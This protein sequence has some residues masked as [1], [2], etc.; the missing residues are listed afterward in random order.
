QE[1]SSKSFQEL[2]SAYPQTTQEMIWDLTRYPDL[3]PL[4]IKEG[5]AAETEL[6]NLLGEYPEEVRSRALRAQAD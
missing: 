4:L 3:L 6:R 2:L 5:A 1:S